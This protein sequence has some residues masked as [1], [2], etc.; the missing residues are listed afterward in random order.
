ML[1][2]K[3]KIC[4]WCGK[5]NRD[6]PVDEHHYFRRVNDRKATIKLCRECHDLTHRD[7]KFFCLIKEMALRN[8]DYESF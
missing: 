1:Q 7:R 8:K 6:C 4:A 2:R 3:E 5:S